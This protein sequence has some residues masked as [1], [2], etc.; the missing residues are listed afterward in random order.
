MSVCNFCGKTI[1]TSQPMVL[2]GSKKFVQGAGNGRVWVGAA[3]SVR[4]WKTFALLSVGICPECLM[5]EK[6][7]RFIFDLSFGVLAL[8][9]LVLYVLF[10]DDIPEGFLGSLT[11]ILFFVAIIVL[12]ISIVMLIKNIAVFWNKKEDWGSIAVSHYLKARRIPKRDILAMP[13]KAGYEGF[14]DIS[15]K[16][17]MKVTDP[18]LGLEYYYEL[19][20]YGRSELENIGKVGDGTPDRGL[21]EARQAAR[22]LFAQIS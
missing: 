15:I 13:E 17:S 22:L 6:R 14:D 12:L 10:N 2:V 5:K 9:Y 18:F 21:D 1:E 4:I 11:G 8:I 16:D 20:L 3:P 7:K 19:T